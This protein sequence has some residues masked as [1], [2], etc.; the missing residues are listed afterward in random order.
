MIPDGKY[1]GDP[2]P[3]TEGYRLGLTNAK[4]C[5]FYSLMNVRKVMEYL[6]LDKEQICNV[7][8]TL[9]RK[10]GGNTWSAEEITEAIYDDSM[11]G[12]GFLEDPA[13]R[14]EV[15]TE[16]VERPRCRDKDYI[17]IMFALGMGA[18]SL[19]LWIATILLT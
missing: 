17:G 15:K 19:G 2:F 3:G 18:L 10:Y 5:P 7:I 6:G 1:Y 4:W 9:Y 14:V 16:Y 11:D 12:H 8:T 13:P